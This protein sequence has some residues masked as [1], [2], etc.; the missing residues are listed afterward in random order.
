MDEKDYQAEF[1]RRAELILL[2]P[3]GSFTSEGPFVYFCGRA[4]LIAAA[5]QIAEMTVAALNRDELR[6]ERGE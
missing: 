5:P 2:N 1:Q 3:G 6:E 4:W